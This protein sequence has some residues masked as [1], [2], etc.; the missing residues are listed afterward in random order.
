MVH[1]DRHI[2]FLGCHVDGDKHRKSGFN[3]SESVNQIHGKCFT[4]YQ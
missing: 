2:Y 4:E 3:L 1:N